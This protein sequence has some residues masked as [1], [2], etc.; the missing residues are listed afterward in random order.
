MKIT[1]RYLKDFCIKINRD[2][3]QEPFGLIVEKGRA[4][5][6]AVL[7]PRKSGEARVD[8][9]EPMQPKELLCFVKGFLKGHETAVSIAIPQLERYKEAMAKTG[10]NNLTC[11]DYKRNCD[12]CPAHSERG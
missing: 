8:L 11:D 3:K 2:L 7:C 6:Y 5:Y 10:C 12:V 9:S 1:E 4:G